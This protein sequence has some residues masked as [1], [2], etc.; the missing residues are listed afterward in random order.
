MHPQWIVDSQL[1]RYLFSSAWDAYIHSQVNA[2]RTRQLL[3]IDAT[4]QPRPGT[5]GATVNRVDHSQSPS[6]GGDRMEPN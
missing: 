3:R 4:F 1:P 6:T 2:H 5:R